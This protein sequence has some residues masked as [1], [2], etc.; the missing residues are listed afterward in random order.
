VLHHRWDQLNT[1][2]QDWARNTSL[3]DIRQ[4]VLN[5]ATNGAQR[6]QWKRAKLPTASLK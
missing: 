5:L 2:F 6:K 3:E 4:D 1:Q